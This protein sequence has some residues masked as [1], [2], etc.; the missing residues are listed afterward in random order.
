ME[1]IIT[2]VSFGISFF[3]WKVYRITNEREIKFFS[4][5]FLSISV[6]YLFWSALNMIMLTK[7]GG[8]LIIMRV[9]RINYLGAGLLVSYFALLLLGFVTL[10]Y[11][12]F[13]TRS[14]RN[15]ILLVGLSL[16]TVL[17]SS[18]KATAFYVTSIFLVLVMASHYYLEYFSKRSVRRLL[19]FISFLLMFV[20]RAELYLGADSYV[21]YMI[22][23][24][25]ELLGY[26]IL[27]VNLLVVLKNGKEKK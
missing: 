20:G 24:S 25:V 13:K 23:H 16:L 11:A 26:A 2:L 21:H 18:N 27:L 3:S 4:L 7:L 1:I 8:D 5:G 9:S 15:Y 17:L 14:F 22:G 12:T 6:S 10:N 19:T